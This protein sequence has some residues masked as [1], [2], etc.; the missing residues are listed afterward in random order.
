MAQVEHKKNILTAF[1]DKQ[2]TINQNPSSSIFI[3]LRH[4]E[5]IGNA[6]KKHQGQADFPLTDLGVNQV[7]QLAAYWKRAEITFDLVIS[8]PLTRAKE[9]AEII[10]QALKSKLEFDPIW[11]ER[12][13][14]ELAGLSHEK[15]LQILPPPDF[16]P[17]YQPIA[18]TG[19]SQWDLYLRAGKAINT[20]MKRPS[21]VYLIV[22]HG[23]LLNMVMR[24][25]LGI[26]PQPNFQGPSF[27]YSNTGYT[28]LEYSPNKNSWRLLKHNLTDHLEN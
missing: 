17:L 13:N 20:L 19:E 2:M 26:H 24:A 6:E 4:G 10:T 3:F 28:K 11:M 5:S 15:A 21:G 9:S 16:I 18:E 22:S 23:G 12:D 25:I 7:T 8:S 14:G 27:H 1:K